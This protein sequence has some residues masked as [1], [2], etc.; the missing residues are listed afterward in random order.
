MFSSWK[1]S[2]HDASSPSVLS[3]LSAYSPM[4]Q[5]ILALDS[6]LSR[7]L[8][9]VRILP[10]EVLDDNHGLLDHV[11]DL[12]LDEVEEGGDAAFYGLVHLHVTVAS[13]N[14]SHRL[15]DKVHVDLKKT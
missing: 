14:G 1:L 5:I 10:G 15:S 9:F 3:I 13:T 7:I 6:S 12:G 8:I 2:M 11:I 4:N